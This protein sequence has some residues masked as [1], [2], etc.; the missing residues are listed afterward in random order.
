M[1]ARVDGRVALVT[2]ASRGIGEA[3]AKEL[4]ASGARGVVITSRKAEN[5]E[6][7]AER[8]GESDR[9][10]AIAARS[11]T[12]EDADRAVAAAVEHFGA[13]DILVNNAGTNAAPGN[14]VDV[15]LAAVDKT[16][17]VNQRGPLVYTQAVWRGWMKD[18][19]GVICN[20]ASV[21]GLRPGPF[22]GAYNISKAALIFMTKQLALELA[23]TVRVNA[24]APAVVKT[25]LSEILWKEDE[26]VAAAS[27]PL[28]R[29]G[30]VE[31][32]ANAVVFLC[33]EQ[34]SWITGVTLEVDGG[35]VNA[36]GSVTPI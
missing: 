21:G 31:D 14:L 15:D 35:V 18:H 7:A 23:P 6:G 13:C 12:V 2:G 28:K 10:L 17:A 9:V 27:H 20:T 5:L 4:L 19:G 30:E 11:D 25:R 1:E 16:W 32:V 29:L 8:L 22:I 26:T 3:I 34:G 36:S 33:S 24:V